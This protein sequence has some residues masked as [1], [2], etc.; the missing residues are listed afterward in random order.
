MGRKNNISGIRTFVPNSSKKEQ[1]NIKYP[2]YLRVYEVVDKLN[3]NT[4]KGLNLQEAQRRR[5]KTGYNLLYPEFKR[6]FKS[7]FI[8]H[9]KTISSSL[10]A[11]SLFIFFAFTSNIYN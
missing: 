7:A 3:T 6:T 9:I 5:K 4:E 11:V 1:K 10:L 2:W 8:D